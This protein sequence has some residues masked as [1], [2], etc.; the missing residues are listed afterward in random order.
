MSFAGLPSKLK[1]IVPAHI[2]TRVRL[3]CEC[4]GST[5]PPG[6]FLSAPYAPFAGS[7]QS[8]ACCAPLIAG[9]S[10][11]FSSLADHIVP[12]AAG[13]FLAGAL[14]AWALSTLPAPTAM[15]TQRHRLHS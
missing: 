1:L 8:T 14:P 4:I 10:T 13:A 5:V 11:H 2:T 12:F 6:T 15:L 7:P 9:L 3:E